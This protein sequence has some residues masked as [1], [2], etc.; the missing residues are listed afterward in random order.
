MNISF[1]LL[2]DGAMGT[3]LYK[4]GFPAGE[5]PEKWSLEHPEV[6]RSI[7]RAYVD[8]GSRIL[9]A[10]TFGANSAVLE[11]NG[12]FNKVKEYNSRLV[13][14]AKEAA[15]GRAYVAGDISST[16][17]MLYPLGDASFE[18]LYRV[19]REQ[20][21]AL[22][23]A[24][25]DLFVI[26][27]M[28]NVAEARAALLAV[29]DVSSKPVFVSFTCD[30]KGRTMT[31]TDVCAALLVMQGMGADAFGLNCSVGPKELIPQLRRLSALSEI[32]LIAKPNA[33]LPKSAG[34]R[35]IY[36]VSPEEFASYVPALA[37]AGVSVFGGCC[38]TDERYIAALRSAL[39]SV[40][41]HAAPAADASALLPCA[42]EREA[43]LL[44]ADASVCAEL[45]CDE[46]LEDAL[47]ET[48]P[49]ELIAVSIRTEED[50]AVFSDCQYGVSN[51]LCIRC[52]DAS[53]LERALRAYQG[54]A[55]YEGNLP[56]DDLL[57]LA[58]KYG[59]I[60]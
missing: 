43:F 11:K 17:A 31:G 38:G 20:A 8:A 27:T 53:L 4:N 46:D 32:P 50:L 34:F 60:F 15:D 58:R 3:Q 52:E 19:Y 33:G 39:S 30:E 10:P 59:L 45:A 47:T 12:V 40:T 16:G 21:E 18:D 41:L 35:T 2:L 13:A 42:T 36:D 1:P 7:Q 48:E 44:P 25:V 29:K 6:V 56:D 55:L 26:E 28:M 51:P 24:G 49:G 57:P 14:L 37:D 23:E 54:R 9:Y 5:C 22:E